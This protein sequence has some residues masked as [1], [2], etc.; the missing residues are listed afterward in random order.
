MVPRLWTLRQ[1]HLGTAESYGYWE[2][3]LDGSIGRC[4]EIFDNSLSRPR[5]LE[6]SAARLAKM[7]VQADHHARLR[8]KYERAARLPGSPKPPTPRR[9]IDRPDPTHDADRPRPERD[10][11][12]RPR[13][14][15]GD[16]AALAGS[17]ATPRAATRPAGGPDGR[18]S[19]R[20]SRSPGSSGP[21]PTRS[22]SPRAGPRP[23]TWPSS[24]WP[25]GSTPGRSRPVVSSPI[26]HPA[27]AEAVARLEA[28]RASRSTAPRSTPRGEGRR[29]GDGRL[30]P[31]RDPPGDL[32]AGQQRDRRDPAGRRAGRPRRSACRSTPTPSRPSAGASR[33]TSG[34]W[35][36]RPWPPAPTSSTGR[37]GIGLLLV[38]R[39]VKLPPR[40]FGGGQ[41]G[42]RRP[43]TPA[44]A[45]AVGM[46]AAPGPLASRGRRPG[47]P[48]G[49]A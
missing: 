18:W 9:R 15:R 46:A 48:L 1:Q 49:P 7:R 14:L 39:G 33:S 44:V 29:P 36:W 34:P 19:G 8:A 16:A 23:T 35:A 26:E 5:G 28:R 4:Q 17:G 20:G 25:A 47:R 45:L 42:G 38:R 12:A 43:G 32:D 13:G 37:P 24:A 22:S 10:H 3:R 31:R 6:P 30:G 41:Q 21:G 2:T 40:A 11:P 27:V